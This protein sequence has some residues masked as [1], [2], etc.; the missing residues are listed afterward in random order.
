[1]KMKRLESSYTT[2]RHRCTGSDK[3]IYKQPA[4]TGAQ[5]CDKCNCEIDLR[6]NLLSYL[7]C[8]LH[9]WCTEMQHTRLHTASR[10]LCTEMQHTRLHI[11]S[12]YRSTGMRKCG[13][14]ID[15]GTNIPSV[16]V[17]FQHLQCTWIRQVRLRNRSWNK[18]PSRINFV[19]ASS[20]RGKV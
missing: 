1:M 3:C 12:R 7:L 17:M 6:T 4:I 18:S 8:L 9:L 16:S 19:F 15:L 5:G 13:C 2:C 11:A 14:E 10:H 20:H